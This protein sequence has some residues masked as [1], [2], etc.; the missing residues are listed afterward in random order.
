MSFSPVR[1]R[2]AVPLHLF[3]E[4]L[5]KHRDGSGDVFIIDVEM[6]Y[7]ADFSRPEGDGEDALDLE[8][9][10]NLFRCYFGIVNGNYDNISFHRGGREFEEG[11]LADGVCQFPCPLVVIGEAFDMMIQGVEPRR[12]KDACLAHAAA[13][14]FTILVCRLYPVR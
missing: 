9:A 1:A 14:A 13:E 8:A 2:H 11:K 3:P 12:A 10:D 4:Q 5:F 6:G 7:K